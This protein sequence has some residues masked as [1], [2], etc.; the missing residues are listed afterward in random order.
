MRKD[1][2]VNE[3]CL[4]RQV[5]PTSSSFALLVNSLRTRLG[6]NAPLFGGCGPPEGEGTRQR[7]GR[8]ALPGV[9]RRP[10]SHTLRVRPP[11]TADSPGACHCT[12]SLSTAAASPGSRYWP[13]LKTRPHLQTNRHRQPKSPGAYSA[14]RGCHERDGRRRCA[15]SVGA[16]AQA[17][18]RS[19]RM[20]SSPWAMA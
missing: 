20:N 16:A 2:P 9:R 7:N 3:S 13:H 14:N 6:G 15:E 11:L 17:S 10:V 8:N 4:G 12:S 19:T 5:S 18:T 1:W